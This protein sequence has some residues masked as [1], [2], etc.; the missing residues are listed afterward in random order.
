MAVD[1]KGTPGKDVYYGYGRIN[2]QK[3]ISSPEKYQYRFTL[4]PFVDR[5]WVNVTSKPGGTLINGK[6]NL[7]SPDVGYPAPVLGWAS[8][9]NFEMVFDFR[10]VPGYYEL[11]LLVGTVSTASGKLYRTTDGITWIGPTAITLVPFAETTDNS[12]PGAN[13][14]AAVEPQAIQYVEGLNPTQTVDSYTPAAQEFAMR[15]VPTV[16]YPL[17]KIE[18]MLGLQTGPITVQLRS[19]NSSGYPSSTV[20]KQVTFTMSSTVSWQG[21]EFAT[22][23]P[24]VAGTPYWIVFTAIPG[25]RSPIAT[26]GTNVTACWDFYSTGYGWDGKTTQLPYMAKFYRE[27][28]PAFKY[29]FTISGYADR[30]YV[31]VTSQSGGTLIYGLVNLTSYSVCYSAPVLGW[32]S[33]NNFYMAFDYRTAVGSGCFELGFM[34]GTVSTAGGSLYRTYDGTSV[35]GP[36]AITLVPFAEASDKKTAFPSAE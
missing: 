14:A 8:G 22:P 7:T 33:G 20:L 19:E 17:K 5:V 25:M 18:L 4:S 31:N 11:G 26:T 16:S 28:Q 34:I 1:D 24:V 13:I 12:E 10:T 15:Y 6:M 9:N 2:C 29:H 32:A 35:V 21:A 3:V 36:T 30:V 27:V 23:Y